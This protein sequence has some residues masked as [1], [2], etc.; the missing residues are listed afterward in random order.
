[1]SSSQRYIEHGSNLITTFGGIFGAAWGIGW[2]SGRAITS[3]PGYHQNVRLPLQRTLGIIPSAPKPYE[4][5][6][7]PK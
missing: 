4:C 7:C 6:L 5:V 3:I 2:E 1:M